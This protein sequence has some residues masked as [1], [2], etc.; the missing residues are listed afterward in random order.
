VRIALFG[1]SFH[2]PHVGHLLAASYVRAV[3]PVDELWFLP[4]A[5]HAFG[6]Q[7]APFVERAEL[8]EALSTLVPGSRVCRIEQELDH[9]GRTLPVVEALLARHPEHTFR[10]VVGSDIVRDIPKWHRFD[11]LVALAP[12][13][14]LARGGHP[15]DTRTLPAGS[16]A[17]TDIRLPEVSST[18]VREKIDRGED[19]SALVPRV[20]RALLAR[21]TERA[22]VLP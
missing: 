1:G 16:L 8:C 12:L 22:P 20:V 17:L 14:V 4:V 3:A 10:L 5:R 15:V 19:V 18:L 7:L 9:G 21:G 2:P 11:R 13:I 6:K